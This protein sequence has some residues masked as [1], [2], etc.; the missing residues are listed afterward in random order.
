MSTYDE[1]LGD[2]VELT[3]TIKVTDKDTFVKFLTPL[4]LHGDQSHGFC[5][6]S[7]GPTKFQDVH[8]NEL[9]LLLTK[10]QEQIDSTRERL[11]TRG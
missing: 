2:N 3:L 10:L 4:F 9:E 11:L 1:I 6:S 7:F 5:L 8:R